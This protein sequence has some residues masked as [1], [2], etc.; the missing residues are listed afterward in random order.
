MRSASTIAKAQTRPKY[1]FGGRI[2]RYCA[3]WVFVPLLALLVAFSS[4]FAL[5]TRAQAAANTTINFQARILQSSGALVPD[6]DYHLEFKIYNDVS[7]GATAQGSCTGNCQWVET[8]IGANVVRVVNGYV[9]VNLG[10][11]TAFPATMPWDQDLY[12]TMRVGGVGGGPVWDTEMTNAG[13]RMKTNVTPYAFRAAQAFNVFSDPTSTASTNTNAIAIQ[14]GNATG[15]T[16]NSGSI[17]IDSGTATGTTGT[18]SIGSTNSSGVLVGRSGITTQI[19]GAT[20]NGTTDLG[21]FG[22]SGSIGTAA[23]TVNAR[24][25][26]VIPQTTASVALTLPAPTSS[27]AGRIVYVANTGTQAFTLNGTS[28]AIGTGIA[29]IWNG[30]A[31]A[32]VGGAG[33]GSTTLQQAYDNAVGGIV[34]VTAADGALRVRDAAVTFGNANI[35]SVQNNAGAVDYL[36]V[37]GDGDVA[38]DTN[39]LFV[40]A[41]N[42]R[43]G[44][45]TAAPTAVLQVT[46]AAPAI[47]AGATGTAQILVANLAGGIGGSTSIATTGTGGAGGGLTYL[48]GSGGT[49]ASALTSST[50]GAG[51][52]TS[53][54]S[55]SGGAAAVAG[56]GNNIGGSGGA[57]TLQSGAGGNATGAT[58]GNNTGGSGGTFTLQAGAGGTA[59]TGSGNLVGG[60]GGA[61]NI[62]GGTGGIGATSGGNGGAVTLQGGIAAA[63]PGAA[64]GAVTVA[65]RAGSGTGS[66]GTGGAL[67]LTAGSAGGDNTVNRAGGSVTISAGASRG[68]TAGG[69]ITVTAGNA[70][71]NLTVGASVAGA[72]SGGISFNAGNG[73]IAPNATTLST[74][75][76]AGGFTV[77]GGIGGAASVGGAVNNTGGSGGTSSFTGGTGGIANGATSGINTG[78]T[79]GAFT[80]QGGTGGAANTGSGSLIGGTGGALSFSGG[81][82]GLGATSGGNGGGVTIQGGQAAAMAGAAGGSVSIS[83]RAGST[84]GTGGNGGGLSL[85]GGAA[86]G[87]GLVA[88]SG[89]GVS[90]TAGA[91]NGGAAGGAVTL[92]AGAGGNNAT[93]GTATGG[94]AGGITFNGSNGGT[95][96]NATVSSTGG[97]A[98]GFTVNG[99]TGGNAAVAGTGNNTGGNGGAFTLGAGTGGNATGATSGINTGGLGG[100]LSLTAGN[101]GSATTGSGTLQGGNGGSLAFSAGRGGAGT[102]TGVGGDITFSTTPTTAAQTERLRVTNSGYVGIGTG[103]TTSL[104]NARLTVVAEN[105]TT[106]QIKLRSSRSA[107]V[108]NDVVGGLDFDTNDTNLT[109]PGVTSARIQAIATASQG[110]ATYD[111]ALVFSTASGVTLAERWRIGSTGE[112]QGNGASTIRAN[113]GNLTIATL[114]SGN[115]IINGAGTFEVQDDINIT[116]N[117]FTNSASTVNSAQAIAND[118]NGGNIGASAAATVDVDTAFILTQTTAGQTMTLFSPTST[119]AGRL[120]YVTNSPSS[121][122]TFTLYSVVIPVGG[123]QGYIWNGS[124][125]TALNVAGAGSGVTTVGLI[126]SQTKNSNGAVISG[127][128]IYLQ[129]ADLTNVGL[130]S[131]TSQSIAGAKTFS[132]LLSGSAGIDVSGATTNINVSSNFNTNINTGS[133]T[134]TLTVGNSA[135]TTIVLGTTNIN[136]SGTAGTSIGNATGALA[137]TGSTTLNGSFIQSGAVSF[138]TGTG[139]VSLN[140]ATSVTGSNTLTVGSGLTTLGGGLAVT[141]TSSFAGN[142]I[143]GGAASGVTATTTAT[144]GVATTT[145]NL[146]AGAFADNDVIYINNAGQDYYTRIVSGGGT[147]TLTVSPSVD[148]DT[149][150]TV[151]RY[152]VQNIGATSTD[153]TT[154]ANRFFQGYFLGG[155]VVGSGSTTLSDGN[156]S[157]TTGDIVIN[158][159]TG[160]VLQVNGTI[161]ATTIIGDGAGITNIDS[162]AIDGATITSLDADNISVGTL[163]DARLSANVALLSGSASFA[164]AVTATGFTGDGSALTALNGTSIT[165][166]TVADGRLS[167]NIAQL[168]LAQSFSALKTFSAGA[169]ITAGQT[170]AINGE[171]FT[172]LTGNGLTLSGSTL[173]VLYGS[174]ANTAVEGNI[175]ITCPSGTGNLSGGG[176]SITLGSG[177]TCSNI[178]TNNAVSF[179]TSVTSP[180]FTGAG[181]VTLGSGGAGDLTLD[182]ASNVL[183]MSDATLRRIASGTTTIELNDGA[184]TTLSV[185]NTNGAAV[186]NLSVEGLVS[187]ASLSGDGSLI[188]AINGTNITTGTVADG[189]LSSNVSLLNLAQSFSALKTFS[190]GATISV[191]QTFTINGEGFTD[192]TGNG[193]TLSGSSLAV[194]Y[195]STANT[196]VEGNT[197]I[198]ITAGTGISGGGAITLGAGGSVSLDIDYGSLAGTAV[199]GNTTLTCPSGSGNLTGGG[200]SITLGTGGTCG[201]IS[202]NNAVTFTTSVTSPLFTSSGAISL[203]SGGANTVSIDAG[204]ASTISIA[205]TNATAVNIG[206]TTGVTTVVAG[207]SI[208]LSSG[209]VSTV[210]STVSANSVTTGTAMQISATSLTT[211]NALDIVGPGSRSLLRVQNNTSDPL[212]DQRVIIG[213]GGLSVSKPDALARDQLYVF[214][215]INYSWNMYSQD[216]LARNTL[217]Q[218][219]ADAAIYGAVFDEATG[220]SGGFNVTSVAGQSGTAILDNPTTAAANENSWFGSGGVGSTE[221]SLNPVFEAR[222]LGTANTDHRI[223]AGFA[224]IA[225]NGANSADTNQSANEIFFRKNQAATVWQAVTRSA[226]GVET[227]T[228]TAITTNAYRTL[229]IEV[230]NVTPRV[231][232]VIDGVV[233]ATHTTALPGST[234]RLGWY[235]GNAIEATT[236]RATSIDYVRVWSDDP[237]ED[238][239]ADSIGNSDALDSGTLPGPENT[240]VSCL[241]DESL[242]PFIRIA[243]DAIY[244]DSTERDSLAIN[245]TGTSGNLIRLQRD[246]SDVLVVSNN[247]GL[248][249]SAQSGE[250]L[251]IR[252]GDASV[253]SVNPAGKLVRVGQEIATAEPILFVLS[254]STSSE[255]PTGTNGAQYYNASTNRFRCFEN[256]E[257]RNC[258]GGATNAEFSLLSQ[259]ATWTNVPELSTELLG[260]EEHRA[261]IDM[262]FAR[263]FRITYGVG[264]TIGNMQCSFEYSIN[265]G[266]DWASLT[267]ASHTV[268]FTATGLQKS[269]WF[270][271]RTEAKGEVL[272]RANCIST[273]PNTTVELTNLKIQLR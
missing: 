145:I 238:S 228:N 90:L 146:T 21:N 60:A 272:V 109:A 199:Q 181:A 37:Q 128:T 5:S 202:T 266:V 32:L 248:T 69:T 118:I 42:N 125:W 164:G 48:G 259:K 64:G 213:Q 143:G 72:A 49:A 18:V 237:P 163:N 172:D 262:S 225:L 190:A 265:N 141:G 132:D 246:A 193:L 157:R 204:G 170:F 206:R 107:I 79:G 52:A 167:T 78:G 129:S 115:V 35:F 263:E 103:T 191:G 9:S 194:I 184:D 240:A 255:D 210:A 28:V 123:T 112:L 131:T 270:Q 116:S 234:T 111:T 50:G 95:A 126:D 244:E 4:I 53:L 98:G 110:A 68:A 165:T 195:G 1:N 88:R 58:S 233:V 76:A 51:G 122:T 91:S 59:T 273:Q 222:I 214:G 216:F 150:A 89:G 39:T 252:S 187:A 149:S 239:I 257:W 215:R 114:T 198:T 108:A 258:I 2:L 66:G 83:G 74:G 87:N 62:N 105:T 102:A 33:G 185:F 140:G 192:L 142:L 236:N 80:F 96:P 3:T 55:G 224:D 268:G 201:A 200:T 92:T 26:F 77:N 8:R 130:V 221:R 208:S 267:A 61:I 6:G 227:T 158:P 247:G 40:D 175:T 47:G 139:A 104:P 29:H 183:V 155:I 168:N 113:T 152:S 67:S 120:V 71:S 250:G 11:V 15:L 19:L 243:A 65:G 41:T 94:N 229:R 271:L 186:A 154:Q 162:S 106:S 269:E 84:T 100:T 31:W 138:A 174:S 226:S 264:A 73:G 254:A 232:F 22:S 30:T 44:I 14:T 135:S 93:A 242:C 119:T 219:T 12:V 137:L 86:G 127:T 166:G 46:N 133:S 99:G 196:S 179:S 197:G 180:L 24:S 17:S 97:T 57:F 260:S 189:R 235:I 256:G 231:L 188:T 101:G 34:T 23:A 45:G 36:A 177:G 230:D 178:T 171:G 85:T 148:Y 218:S 173:A 241:S 144:P 153:Y 209:A 81:T 261:W 207:A 203:T 63:M 16:S 205:G 38:V 20:L 223:I 159:G 151:E 182:S 7:A 220:A 124:A 169:T 249:I 253:F 134:G 75:G 43:V 121:T 161:N 211:G 13:N 70:G 56:T 245:K 147:A 27:I 25:S 136:T 82:G 156:L 54:T 212:D 217:A 176:N 160:G 251:T 10:S 117:Q